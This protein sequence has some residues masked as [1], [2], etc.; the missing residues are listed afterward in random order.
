MIRC[1]VSARPWSGNTPDGWPTGCTVEELDN[2]TIYLPSEGKVLQIS[3]SGQISTLAEGCQGCDSALLTD[4]GHS[5]LLVTHGFGPGA[6][7]G[8]LYRLRLQ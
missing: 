1:C 3:A 5:L 2:G 6:G 8:H 4:H 7:P